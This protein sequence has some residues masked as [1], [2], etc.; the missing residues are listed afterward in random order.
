M[1][2]FVADNGGEEALKKFVFQTDKGLGIAGFALAG[3]A[4]KKLAVDAAGVVALGG[5]DAEAAEFVDAF[6]EAD[7]CSAAGHVGGDRDAA[8]VAGGGDDDGFVLRADGVE[9]G[10][11]EAALAEAMGK[12]FAGGD[13]ACADEDGLAGGVDAFDFGDDGVPFFVGAGDDLVGELFADAGT[14]R[15]NRN[16]RKFVDGPEFV[17]GF[18]CGAGHAG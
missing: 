16:D 1:L 14:V 3:A 9:D 17:S 15:R 7:V 4:A 2:D 12:F 8:G 18:A 10:D 6:V 13:V 5:D 11:F